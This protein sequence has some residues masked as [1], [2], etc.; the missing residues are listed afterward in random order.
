MIAVV[1]HGLPILL[2]W[3]TRYRSQ[4]LCFCD[5]SSALPKI[6][7]PSCVVPNF[8]VQSCDDL[9]ENYLMRVPHPANLECVETD[10]VKRRLDELDELNRQ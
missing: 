2:N 1:V 10:R 5:F 3:L 8:S 4:L 9:D 7:M 6:Y